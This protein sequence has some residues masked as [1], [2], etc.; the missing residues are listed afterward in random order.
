MLPSHEYPFLMEVWRESETGNWKHTY[1]MSESLTDA[2]YTR[3][4]II[5]AAPLA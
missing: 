3:N 2:P 5:I 1:P 4:T